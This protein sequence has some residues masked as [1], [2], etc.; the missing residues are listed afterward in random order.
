MN[1]SKKYKKVEKIGTGSFG[2]IYK[3]MNRKTRQFSVLKEID[4]THMSPD[5][6][7]KTKREV[8]ILSSLDHPMVLK[9][10]ES[11]INE[12]NYR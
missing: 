10:E 7:A 11:F 4:M 2:K 12:S 9:Y 8:T 1:P 5:I 3:V 6:R